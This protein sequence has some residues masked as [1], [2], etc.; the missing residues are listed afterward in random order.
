MDF[1]HSQC[2]GA[3]ALIGLSPSTGHQPCQQ[4]LPASVAPAGHQ[5][6]AYADASCS[7]DR[8]KGQFLGTVPKFR[9]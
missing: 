2:R 9:P 8:Q 6:L 1:P 3:N 7:G 5:R 4:I